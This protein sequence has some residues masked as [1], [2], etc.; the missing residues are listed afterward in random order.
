MNYPEMSG[1]VA[2]VTGGAKGLGKAICEA[3]AANGAK[4]A[5]CDV[6]D[7]SAEI[8]LAALRKGDAEALYVRADIADAND[9]RRLVEK[10][11]E[12]FGRIDF[13]VNNAGVSQRKVLLT[14]LEE[15]DY[16][17]LMNINM[18]GPWLLSKHAI[19][20]M[21]KNGGGAIVNISSAMGLFAQKYVALY[22][23]SKHA[24]LGLTKATAIEFGMQGIRANAICPGRHDTPM[25]AAWRTGRTMTSDEWQAQVERNHPATGRIGRPDEIASATL[26]LCS[27]GASN[28]HGVVLPVDGG[29]SAQ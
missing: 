6:D 13:L 10:A 5:F 18:K 28:I 19:P 4:I 23:A 3:F 14:E 15:E 2:L 24:I 11:A 25:V 29:W 21:L 7:Q 9:V 22:A 20:L 17:R 16:D 27:S 8:T 12:D 1:K 26:F